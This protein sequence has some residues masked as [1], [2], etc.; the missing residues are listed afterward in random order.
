[1]RLDVVDGL[2]D[3]GDLL[4]FLVGNLGLEL[5]LEGHHQL[6]R[7]ERVRAEVVDEGGFILD[8]RLVHPE[9]LGDDLLHAWFDVFHLLLLPCGGQAA[10]RIL[11]NR[12]E[13][14]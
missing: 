3:G 12:L 11:P 7:V 9:L 13:S 8:L 6:H 4:R 10:A 5:L 2:L 1:V 14:L